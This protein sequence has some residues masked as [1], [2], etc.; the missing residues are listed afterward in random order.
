MENLRSYIHQYSKI[1]RQATGLQPEED[2]DLGHKVEFM[3]RLRNSAIANKI[4]KSQQFKEY[5]RYS[6]QSCFAK[7]LELEGK[8]MVGEVVAPRYRQASIL[9]VEGLDPMGGEGACEVKHQ[10]DQGKGDLYNLN[11]CWRCG[12]MGHF[13]QDC[14]QGANPTQAIGKLHHTLKAETPVAK[15]LLTEFFNKLMRVQ[16]K[17]YIV[18]A[19]LKKERQQGK[20]GAP[21]A[22]DLNPKVPLP[23]RKAIGTN[24]PPKGEKK[25]LPRRSVRFQNQT[26]KGKPQP[27]TP[28]ITKKDTV[29]EAVEI[30]GLSDTDC[31]TEELADLPTD[32]ELEG[33]TGETS[34]AGTGTR[35]GTSMTIKTGGGNS[36]GEGGRG[37]KIKYKTKWG[38][39]G[40]Y[41]SKAKWCEVSSTNRHRCLPELHELRAVQVNR[42]PPLEPLPPGAH[43]R[44]ATGTS[45]EAW[46]L[47]SCLVRIGHKMYAQSF[48]VCNKMMTN[49]IVGRDFLS[50]YKLNITWGDE[51]TMEVLEGQEP[52]IKMGEVH[53][54]PAYVGGRA[55]VPLRTVAAVPVFVNLPPF[56]RKT[57]FRFVP[58]KENLDLQTNSLVYPLDYATWRGGHQHTIQIIINLAE[59]PLLLEEETLLGYYE[60]EDEED[61]VVDQEGL[62]ESQHGETLGRGRIGR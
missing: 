29:N 10:T 17:H 45:M 7:A 4:I 28:P 27:A 33:A 31:D 19:K 9:G 23:V 14:T 57:L 34:G 13:A 51:G 55:Q 6:L 44:S 3:K 1:H 18:Q 48:I 58:L 2:Y 42:V 53:Q 26:E 36:K 38:S 59:E 30:E 50:T 11:E 8:F 25:T 39:G 22:A 12:G 32:S 5:T 35:R 52:V 47:T 24:P 60:R 54:Y 20:G 43:L 46:G 56:G 62:F 61:M 15:S 16:R 37:K 49:V 21:G 41:S 40:T